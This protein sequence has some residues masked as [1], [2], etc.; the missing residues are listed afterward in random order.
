MDVR[1]IVLKDYFY[2][3]NKNDFVISKYNGENALN[4]SI[5]NS[6]KTFDLNN[7]NEKDFKYVVLY[8]EN[9]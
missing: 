7:N 9:N 5:F 8:K 2:K 1:I 6:F 3:I 4:I